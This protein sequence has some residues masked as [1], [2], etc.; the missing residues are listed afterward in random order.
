MKPVRL[1]EP[2]ERV[3]LTEGPFSGIEGIY[4]MPDGEQ[5]VVVL[6]E[7]LSREVSVRVGPASL[8]KAS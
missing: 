4:Q 6:I 1:F 8:R 3:R 2:G 7:L 5:R